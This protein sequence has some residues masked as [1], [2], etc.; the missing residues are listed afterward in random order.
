MQILHKKVCVY[1]RYQLG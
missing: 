1:H